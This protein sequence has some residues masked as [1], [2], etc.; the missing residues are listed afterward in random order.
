MDISSLTPNKQVKMQFWLNAIR[1]CRSSG[2]TNQAWCEQNNLSLKSYYYWIA[3]IRKL[4]IE[5]IPRKDHGLSLPCA[6]SQT[7]SSS[8]EI[9]TEVPVPISRQSSSD[10]AAV[11]HISD[12]TIDISENVSSEFLVSILKAVRS[13]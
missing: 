1:E 12:I 10:F 5:D 9:F 13:C 8:D 11:I 4:A 2:L 3:K 6:T 7:S